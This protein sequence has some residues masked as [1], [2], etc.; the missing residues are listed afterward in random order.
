[1]NRD[2]F[3]KHLDDLTCRIVNSAHNELYIRV[4]SDT[5]DTQV[6]LNINQFNELWLSVFHLKE[7][8]ELNTIPN[9]N[10]LSIVNIE[11]ETGSKGNNIGKDGSHADKSS[12]HFLC[13]LA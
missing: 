9:I 12:H 4:N 1:M 10:G 11:H 13:H 2:L 3:E 7:N 8:I 6:Y 5:A